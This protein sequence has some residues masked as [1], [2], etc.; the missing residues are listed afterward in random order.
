MRERKAQMN[1]VPYMIILGDSE[2]NNNTI[3]VRTRKGTNLNNI[4]CKSF[5]D[6]LATE[7]KEKLMNSPYE[8]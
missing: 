3:S 8:R 7:I 1:K 5:I 4:S 2:R 6:T